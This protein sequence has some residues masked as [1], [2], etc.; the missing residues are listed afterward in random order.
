MLWCD[1]LDDAIAMEGNPISDLH[2]RPDV[3]GDDDA[4]GLELL[5]GFV[6]ELVD[7]HGCDG[8][9][10]CCGFV[11]QNDK[12][13][14]D[15]QAGQCRALFIPPERSDGIFDSTPSKPT[16]FRASATRL[17]ISFSPILGSCCRK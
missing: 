5:L 2:R 1:L 15:D 13:S 3:M 8:I 6:D 16:I 7:L 9:E 14:I 12:R 17:L 10:P 11:I 4:C